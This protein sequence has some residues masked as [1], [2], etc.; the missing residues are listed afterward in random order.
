MCARQAGC[1]AACEGPLRH[2]RVGFLVGVCVIGR[3]ALTVLS[4]RVYSPRVAVFVRACLRV[5]LH[6]LQRE[7]GLPLPCLCLGLVSLFAFGL[8]AVTSCSNTLCIILALLLHTLSLGLLIPQDSYFFPSSVLHILDC[9]LLPSHAPW[10][11]RVFKN[12]C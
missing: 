3:F 8:R 4:A 12:S 2:I 7:E 1:L 5:C 10:V 9:F 6:W 11:Y